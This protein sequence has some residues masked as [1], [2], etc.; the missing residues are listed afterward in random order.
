MESP[1]E[2]N[3]LNEDAPKWEPMNATSPSN[4]RGHPPPTDVERNEIK[5]SLALTVDAG[6]CIL[7][8]HSAT[9]QE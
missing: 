8:V 7:A 3:P 1:R 4:H 6:F 2:S 5:D 9:A